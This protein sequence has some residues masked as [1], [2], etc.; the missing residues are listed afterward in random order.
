MTKEQTEWLEQQN[1]SFNLMMQSPNAAILA[2]Y[3]F[4]QQI[5]SMLS[6]L[7]IHVEQLA[8][9]AESQKPGT[10]CGTLLRAFAKHWPSFVQNIA[11]EPG[12]GELKWLD[13]VL[14]AQEVS[15]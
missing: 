11:S 5:K 8:A 12:M 3:D 7:P 15:R 9:F 1:A 2:V 10:L 13:T 4:T 6:V 14:A